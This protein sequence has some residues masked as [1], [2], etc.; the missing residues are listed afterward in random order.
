MADIP[1]DRFAFY[2][3]DR[4]DYNRDSRDLLPQIES[5]LATLFSLS[6]THKRFRCLPYPDFVLIFFNLVFF[7]S[8]FPLHSEKKFIFLS[9]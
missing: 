2:S 1:T 8:R 3:R 7:L 4:E 6:P 5:P 9:G